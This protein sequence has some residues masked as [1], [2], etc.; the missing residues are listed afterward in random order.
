[1][2]RFLDIVLAGGTILILSPILLPFMLVLRFTGEGEIFYRQQRVGIGGRNFG[3]LKFATMLKNSPN[4]GAGEITVRNDPRI[5]PLGA[6]LR[7][8]KLNELP[9]LWN[10]VIGDMSIVG[11]RPMVPST[12]EHY[13]AQAQ[14]TLCSVR[15][16][17]TGI[18]SIVFRDEERYLDG[19]ADP[20]KF[21]RGVI[22]PH[23]SNLEL[24]YVSNIS[25]TLY[26]KIIVATAWVIV[27]PK[28]NI[29]QLFFNGLPQLPQELKEIGS[30]QTIA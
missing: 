24:W 25:L 22:I 5:L 20:M 17:L 8:T 18:G 12:F 10:I 21:Y 14:S 1:M 3:L 27:F 4:I 9:Q 6:F 19:H 13:P 30:A 11:P 7:K 29:T 23:K 15:P 16:G 26:L 28:S 2:R